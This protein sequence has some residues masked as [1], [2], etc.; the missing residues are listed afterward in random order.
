MTATGFYYQAPELR[1]IA[2]DKRN[3]LLKNER[4]VHY[5][6]GISAYL[7]DD[8]RLTTEI[9]YKDF[10]DLI[11]RSDRS[12]QL[13]SNDGTG[14]SR[15]ID[16]GLVKKFSGKWYGQVNYSYSESKRNDND[17]TG[18]YNDDLSQP[19]N[20]N[21]LIGYE[22]NDEWS[23]STKWKYATGIPTDSYIIHSNVLNNPNLVRYSKEITDNNTRRLDDFHSLNIR[24]DY[25][26]Q[27]GNVPL[28]NNL[29]IVAFID[30]LNV[31]NRLNVNVDEFNP[32][33]GSVV[34]EGVE[35]LPT[36]GVKLEL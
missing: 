7:S 30:I 29:A 28:V 11:V 4:A 14:Y 6:A 32:V 12:T 2:M 13:R 1:I 35:I 22:L 27:F 25:R 10:S 18:E 23:F 20:F 15:G 21:I 33:T 3:A 19:H 36:I 8:I 31:Y 5:I 26:H 34:K 16:I 24:I 9:Y 17:G